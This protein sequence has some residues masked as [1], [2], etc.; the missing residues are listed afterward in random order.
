[1]GKKLKAGEDI[2]AVH[3]A[4]LAVRYAQAANRVAEVEALL[5]RQRGKVA[6]LRRLGFSQEANAAQ[7]L[8][9]KIQTLLH[10]CIEDRDRII[11]RPTDG[12]VH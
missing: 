1:M 8:L 6:G 9:A 5:A 4:Q 10:L 7:P 2:S 12:S 11:R 3:N